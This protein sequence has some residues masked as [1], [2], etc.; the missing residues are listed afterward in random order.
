MTRGWED[1]RTRVLDAIADGRDQEGLSAL[2][3]ALRWPAK[4]VSDD[5][6]SDALKLLGTVAGHLGADD[7]AARAKNASVFRA[8]GALQALALE[9][10]R[11]RSPSLAATILDRAR[12]AAP[13]DERILLDLAQALEADFQSAAAI[14]VL[15]S[16]PDAV[17]KT[18]MVRWLR[19]YHGLI[20]GD[21]ELPRRELRE[22][23]ALPDT[24][25][26]LVRTLE[27]MVLRAGA[28]AKVTPLDV[29][30]LRGWQAVMDGSLLLHVS[31]HGPD[32][33]RGRYGFLQDSEALC[34]EGIARLL[35]V[36]EGVGERP[37]R[38]VLLP[39]RSSEIL[40]R[41][42]AE[43][44]GVAAEEWSDGDTRP[45]LFPAYDLDQLP[46]NVS[47]LLAEHRPGQILFAHAT[48]W[49]DPFPFAA[50][51]TTFQHQHVRAP[52]DAQLELDA[53]SREVIE[54]EPSDEP[55]PELAKKILAEQVTLESLG[56][57]AQVVSL[58]LALRSLGKE[59]TAGLFRDSGRR[60]RQRYGSP[61]KSA[62]FD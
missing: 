47:H 61:V 19:A 21:V 43:R 6:L 22:L 17:K 23:S 8:P 18:F 7:L 40:G 38:V 16:A 1:T 24:R 60:R 31:P 51:L 34:A 28:L 46:P 54:S 36:L 52:W 39:E 30:D 59:D 50:D 55:V 32:V 48:C 58:A 11:A 15:D 20:S 56:D 2:I 41:A 5:D 37:Q 3:E 13:N 45:G 57:V 10:Y 44:L 12:A 27:S 14:E 49:T 29:A 33:M 26:E 4:D 62:R 9:L 53:E 35:A 42:I 25:P